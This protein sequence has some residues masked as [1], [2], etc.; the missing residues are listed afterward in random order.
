MNLDLTWPV[1]G[2]A[3]AAGLAVFLAGYCARRMT[4]PVAFSWWFTGSVFAGPAWTAK[5]SWVTNIAAVGA[6]LG[7]VITDSSSTLKTQLASSAPG[8]T[9]LYLVFGGVAVAAPVVY[10][11]TAKL[12][13]QGINDTT[14]SVWGFLLAG[15]ASLFAVLGEIATLA[16]LVT[17][18]SASTATQ[19]WVLIALCLGAL[20]IIVYSVRSLTYFATLPAP[21][22]KPQPAPASAPAAGPAAAPAVP[23]AA[24][25]VPAV[26]AARPGVLPPPPAPPFRRSLLGNQTFSATL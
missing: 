2:A 18:I 25:A 21:R 10:G 15:A 24:P 12:Q 17:S 20:A 11:A 4:G 13:S 14:G 23:A 19:W 22:P 3:I 8:V 6:V 9:L 26:P 1:V 7:S 16:L 5:D